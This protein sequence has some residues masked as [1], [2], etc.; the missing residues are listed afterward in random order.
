MQR[1]EMGCS[2]HRRGAFACQAEEKRCNFTADCLRR[3][4]G[5]LMSQKLRRNSF[6]SLPRKHMMKRS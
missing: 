6:G 5:N 1:H 2:R 4:K 3:E